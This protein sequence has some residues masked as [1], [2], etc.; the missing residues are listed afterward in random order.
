MYD[1][2]EIAGAGY[3]AGYVVSGGSI[4]TETQFAEYATVLWAGVKLGI[5]LPLSGLSRIVRKNAEDNVK[6][7]ENKVRSRY[8]SNLEGA[9]RPV[10]RALQNA[11]YGAFSVWLASLIV[12]AGV[13]IVD[14]VGPNPIEKG[15]ELTHCVFSHLEPLKNYLSLAPHEHIGDFNQMMMVYIGAAGGIMQTGREF[16]MGNYQRLRARLKKTDKI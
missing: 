5:L 13:N 4:D 10:Q 8:L 15:L 1:L 6:E 7:D 14:L 12:D 9:R 2:V 11:A 3:L 16:L